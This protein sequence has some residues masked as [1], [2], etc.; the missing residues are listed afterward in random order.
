[1]LNLEQDKFPLRLSIGGGQAR[2]ED[3]FERNTKGKMHLGRDEKT[4]EKKTK[5]LAPLTIR[6]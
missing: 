5:L 3:D 1:M 6:S 4:V 2:F